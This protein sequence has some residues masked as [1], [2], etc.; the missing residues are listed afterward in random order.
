MDTVSIVIPTHN[1]AAYIREAVDSALGQTHAAVEVIVVDDGSTDGT[2]DVLA[3]Y[4]ASGR[5]QY[6]RTPQR[7]PSA[8]R[9]AGWRLATGRYLKFLDSDDYL[10]P[11]QAAR[12]VEEMDAGDRIVSVSDSVISRP[13][14]AVIRRRPPIDV[15]ERQLAALVAGNLTVVHAL[16][17]PRVLLLEVD[18]FD[19]TLRAAED[20]DLWIRI[21]KAGGVLRHLP[22]V[23]CC[24][25]VLSNSISANALDMFDQKCRVVAKV[26]TWLLQQPELSRHLLESALVSNLTL[27]DEGF[28]RQV[29]TEALAI[30]TQST[31]ELLRRQGRLP[32]RA[33]LAALGAR[34]ALK[35]RFRVKARRDAPYVHGLLNEADLRRYGRASTER[36]M[37]R[38]R[39]SSARRRR[40]VVLMYHRI[41]DVADNRRGLAVSPRHFE[42]QMAV[43]ARSGTP[44]HLTDLT[45]S[46]R[47]R[48]GSQG[49]V[50][51]TFDDGYADNFLRARPVLEQ[52]GVPAT[53]FIVSGAVDSGQ[54]FWWDVL[55]HAVSGRA[56][57][58]ARFREAIAARTCDWS[59]TP[60]Q[61]TSTFRGIPDAGAELSASEL[62]DALLHILLPLSLAEKEAGARCVAAWSGRGFE[63]RPED[64]PMTAAEV[65]TL[66]RSPLFTIGAHTQSH[67]MLAGLP[68]E[69]QAEEIRG[70]RLALEALIGAG[71]TTL[72]YP[73]GD[74]SDVTIEAA[75]R[76]GIALACTTRPR[77]V[78]RSTAPLEVPR[79][80]VRDWTGEEFGRRL[81]AWL[82][83]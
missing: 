70:S 60:R 54:A 43:L 42:E 5:I 20:W 34:R 73:H 62:S 79:F 71:V 8:A 15:P 72:A 26:D 36:R 31:A 11:E 74:C 7:G 39:A 14:G 65:V 23:G 38:L 22:V 33:A 56:P 46:V 9:N 16:L 52:Y 80:K 51:V 3:P 48:P 78:D 66:A 63:P 64:L 83:E 68:A 75:R 40:G 13:D 67:P 44:V 50:A 6:V 21:V 81:E 27:I 76:A 18:G 45:R 35:L 19:E 12:Q 61:W 17:I 49:P 30:L 77:P 53:F 59:I 24:Y 57:L 37:P 69:A 32:V 58:P 82:E 2:Q 1:R 28:A 4:I 41:A 47:A 25:R 29:S 10:F 55:E